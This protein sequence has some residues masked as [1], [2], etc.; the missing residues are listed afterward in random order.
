[1]KQFFT[2]TTC[3]EKSSTAQNNDTEPFANSPFAPR[4]VLGIF[5]ILGIPLLHAMCADSIV[6]STCE[7]GS[8]A[9][10]LNL[11]IAEMS[12]HVPLVD[13][14]IDL[15]SLQNPRNLQW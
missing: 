9:I 3:N 12:A 2:V 1:M 7:K 14:N 8:L 4:L 15:C 10:N 5:E 11:L 13:R 6:S